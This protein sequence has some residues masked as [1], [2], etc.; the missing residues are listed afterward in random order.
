MEIII[1]GKRT[2]KQ[3]FWRFRRFR[4]LL[5]RTLVTPEESCIF[6]KLL[7]INGNHYRSSNAKLIIVLSLKMLTFESQYVNVFTKM[8]K[9]SE[10]AGKK[11][12]E[13]GGEDEGTPVKLILKSS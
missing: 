8:Y 13:T 1:I 10:T 9:A 12:G 4:G 11:R 6:S 5:I 7:H 2:K 3:S